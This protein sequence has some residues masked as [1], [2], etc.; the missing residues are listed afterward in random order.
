MRL[1]L[2][3]LAVPIVLTGCGGGDDST[4]PSN[5]LKGVEQ[6]A[7]DAPACA[8]VWVAGQTL[9]DEYEGCTDE[10]GM[11]FVATAMQCDDGSQLVSYEQ[12]NM[13]VVT[14]GEI[15]QSPVPI[16]EDKD[17]YGAAFAECSGA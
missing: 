6:M 16:A 2:A 10:S 3:A 4:E 15:L 9:P 8:D 12:E 7:E 5:A 17:G 13:W 1:Y 14:P 11:L